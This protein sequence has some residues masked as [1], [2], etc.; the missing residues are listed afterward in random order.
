MEFY[1]SVIYFHIATVGN[2]QKIFDE[3]YFQI[4]KS[5][6]INQVDSINFCLV[7]E[8]NLYFKP[9]KKI[10][11]YKDPYV[12][13]GEFFTLNLIKTFSDSVEENYKILYIHTKGVTTADNPCIDDWR[14]Y[15][16]YFNINQYKKCFEVLD[17]YDSCGVD[18]VND[19]TIH[20]SGNFWWANSLY[21]KKLPTIEEIKFPKTPPLLS[22]RHNCEFWIGMGCGK[23]KSLWNSNINVYERHL[24]RYYKSEYKMKLANIL[25]EFNLN[26]DFAKNSYENGG[27]DKNTCHSYIE[28]F[29]EKEFEPY[30]EKNVELFE[31]G[32]ETGGSLKLWKEYFLN[33]KS[34]IGVD[35]TDEKI[36]KRYKNID[37]V[38]MYFG[39]AYDK[40]FS[41]NFGYFDII[42]DDGPHTLESQLK[43]I[44]LYLPKLRENGLFI[45]EDVQDT[46]WFEILIDKSKHI[47]ESMDN[48]IEYIVECIDLRDSKGRWDD[49]LFLI[50]S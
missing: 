41:D 30:H 15:M 18:L 14:Q 5:N 47:C 32:I 45:I 42:I 11:I 1:K 50:R 10:N 2:Y 34:I 26:A 49:L 23:L 21:I 3:I 22:I 19:P 36:D 9:H 20:Y 4:I 28:N 27:T 46:E 40:N 8:G 13:T 7:G 6:L 31:I 12:E 44:E 48:Q 38:T 37:E 17:N 33:S 24:H 16:T 43:F 25:N 39:D 35:I 29:Y